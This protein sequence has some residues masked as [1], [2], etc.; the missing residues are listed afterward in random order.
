[1]N[2]IDDSKFIDT[3]GDIRVLALT[4]RHEALKMAENIENEMQTHSF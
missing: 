2:I 1:M 4:I 3:F